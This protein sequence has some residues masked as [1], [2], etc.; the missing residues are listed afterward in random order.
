MNIRKIAD[1][2]AVSEQVGAVDMRVIAQAGYRTVI[3]N[4]PDGEGHD[5][6]RFSEIEAAAREAG[7]EAA[8]LP[9]VPGQMTSLHVEHFA[10]LVRTLPGP[11]LGYCRSGARAAG[12]WQAAQST[13]AAG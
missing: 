5:Q 3:C 10:E 11:I 12:L 13:N 6:P 9:I 7:L 4:R 1:E 8:Y 2:F